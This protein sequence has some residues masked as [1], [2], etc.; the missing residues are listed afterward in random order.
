MASQRTAS[1]E[2][3]LIDNFVRKIGG[4]ARLTTKMFRSYDT[5]RFDPNNLMTDYKINFRDEPIVELEIPLDAFHRLVEDTEIIQNLKRRFGPDADRM[6]EEIIT[7]EWHHNKEYRIREN[8]PG[9]KKAWEN[10]QLMLKL[11]GE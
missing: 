2:K 4:S 6:G 7:R 8:N 5:P 9:V 11:A 10:Y 3:S 1:Q